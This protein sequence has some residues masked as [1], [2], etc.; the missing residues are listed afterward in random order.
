MT[1]SGVPLMN[2]AT[3]AR[4]RGYARTGAAASRLTERRMTRNVNVAGWVSTPFAARQYRPGH[5]DTGRRLR[6]TETAAE[7]VEK[8][9]RAH[10]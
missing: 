5:P 4:C 7:V 10:V 9:G 8:I 6:L 3:G 1:C 2:A